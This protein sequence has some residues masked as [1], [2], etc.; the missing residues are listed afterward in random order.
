V[1]VPAAWRVPVSV[2]ALCGAECLK[3]QIQTGR[4]HRIGM[5]QCD[6]IMLPFASP[7]DRP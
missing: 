1:G 6:N 5:I 2:C 4:P 7:G 3:Q